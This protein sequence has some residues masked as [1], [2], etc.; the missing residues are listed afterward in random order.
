MIPSVLN[1]FENEDTREPRKSKARPHP[2]PLSSKSWRGVLAWRVRLRDG[3]GEAPGVKARCARSSNRWLEPRRSP[4]RPTAR[5]KR[6][7][8][9]AHAN[10]PGR[11]R[12]LG[13]PVRLDCRA[14]NTAWRDAY[15]KGAC[16]PF[17]S[18]GALETKAPRRCCLRPHD[19]RS[20]APDTPPRHAP[21]ALA[22]CQ[23]GP[24]TL[25]RRH[26]PAAPAS[27]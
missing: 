2:C 22:G 17:R 23:A 14:P 6:G 24:H 5:S 4:N 26:T 20:T 11:Q 9:R 3:A 13:I 21:A 7:C 25:Q 8:R 16:L 27:V 12:R 15:R 1:T 18:T 19:T 10:P